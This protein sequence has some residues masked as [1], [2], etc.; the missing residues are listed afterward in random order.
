MKNK[1][2]SVKIAIVDDSAIFQKLLFFYLDSYGYNVAFQAENGAECIEI[3]NKTIH[4]PDIIILD[5]NMPVMNGFE[6]AKKIKSNWP[7]IIVIAYSSDDDQY[8]Q[9][10]II[11]CGA[12]KFIY[13]GVSGRELIS[14][15]E[16]YFNKG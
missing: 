10:K 11:S 5:I 1:L 2:S 6:T 8:T 12:D 14:S 16:Y 3:L 15:L 9:E 13:K 7:S 4:H